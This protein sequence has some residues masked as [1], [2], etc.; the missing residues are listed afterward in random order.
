MEVSARNLSAALMSIRM[1][2]PR[3][4]LHSGGKVSTFVQPTD[5]TQQKRGLCARVYDEAV[6]LF[7][8]LISLLLEHSFVVDGE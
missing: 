5:L 2:T 4:E 7:S 3:T 8:N 1:Q 6:K